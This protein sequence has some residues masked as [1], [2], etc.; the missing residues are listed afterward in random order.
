MRIHGLG[1]APATVEGL[2]A[3]GFVVDDGAGAV[4]AVLLGSDSPEGPDLAT[5]ATQ[6]LEHPDALLLV[7]CPPPAPARLL[8]WVRAGLDDWIDPGSGPA[9]LAAGLSASLRRRDI[10]RQQRAVVSSLED[11]RRRAESE[12]RELSDRLVAVATELETEHQRLG[13]ALPS[14][15]SRW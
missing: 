8:E 14:S 6:R 11:R 1:L 10:A 4:D 7:S 3:H 9:G 13:H 5:V 15:S 2:R 12:E